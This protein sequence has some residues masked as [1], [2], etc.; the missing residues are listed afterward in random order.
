[1]NLAPGD[2]SAVDHVLSADDGRALDRHEAVAEQRCSDCLSAEDLW[3]CLVCGYVGCGRYVGGHSHAH[4]AQTQ[5]CYTMELGANRV[6]DYVGDNFVHRLVQTECA[7][8]KLVETGGGRAG[9]DPEDCKDGAKNIDGVTVNSDEKLDSI[10]LEYTYLLT[11]QLEAQR[12]YFEEKIHRLEEHSHQE[13]EEV[14][15]RALASREESKI[16]EEKVRG[17]S[18]QSHSSFDEG[19]GRKQGLLVEG[20]PWKP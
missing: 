14:L 4:F 17:R 7:D 19:R 9:R 1:M 13:M 16:M 18:F 3:I 5:H 2:L 10:Q 6:W 8:G 12:R 11:S 20:M 15:R